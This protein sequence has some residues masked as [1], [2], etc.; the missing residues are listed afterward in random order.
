M[1]TISLTF[2]SIFISFVSVCQDK[3]NF[4]HGVTELFFKEP[5]LAATPDAWQIT[6]S[7]KGLLNTTADEYVAIFNLTQV[8][9][10]AQSTNDLSIKR[11][12]SFADELKVIGIDSTQIHTDLISFV[13]KYSYQLITKM[14]S[15]S[16]NEVPAGFIQQRNISVRFTNAALIEQVVAA[17]AR[18]EIYDLVKVDYFKRDLRKEQEE[19][20]MKCFEAM[21][22]KIK[23][24]EQLGFTLD[25]MTKTFD[26]D[27]ITILPKNRYTSYQA[28]SRP[29]LAAL[30]KSTGE[31]SMKISEAELTRSDYYDAVSFEKYDVVINP[32]VD[33][34][35]IQ[36]CYEIKVQYFLKNHITKQPD[37]K[38]FMVTPAGEVKPF[39][40]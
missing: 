29:S 8:G 14:F 4:S 38:Y 15:K 5:S 26:D 30:K 10:S 13:P 11:I 16:Y 40:F 28:V 7:V 18:V 39:Q 32:V 33:Q 20:K 24:Y 1:K 9:D 6:V 31:S 36:V 37:K 2:I 3:G 17:A 22:A 23:S 12:R 27:M 34:P 25:T 35:V 21:R 19:L